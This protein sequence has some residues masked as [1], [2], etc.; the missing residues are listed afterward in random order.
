M[1]WWPS[2]QNGTTDAYT[3]QVVYLFKCDGACVHEGGS[4]FP[5]SLFSPFLEIFRSGHDVLK[6]KPDCRNLT[7][8]MEKHFRIV[9]NRKCFHLTSREFKIVNVAIQILLDAYLCVT[10]FRMQ[11]EHFGKFY[12]SSTKDNTLARNEFYFL[13]SL[14]FTLP[15]Q[16]HLS[17]KQALAGLALFQRWSTGTHWLHFCW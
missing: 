1:C 13:I 14:A 4:L 8:G 5:P 15:D 7:M 10:G 9:E 17:C 6:G 3:V 2:L 16:K 12:G 11:P